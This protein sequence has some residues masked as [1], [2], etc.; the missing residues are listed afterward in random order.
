MQ[1]IPT[2]HT[3][4]LTYETLTI[5]GVEVPLMTNCQQRAE[6][7]RSNCREELLL[8]LAKVCAEEYGFELVDPD[9]DR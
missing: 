7:Q 9:D 5:N 3:I 1:T 4:A 8:A 6:Y 2:G